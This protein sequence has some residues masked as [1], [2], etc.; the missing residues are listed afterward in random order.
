MLLASSPA[1]GQSWH[2]LYGRG[3]YG[4][5]AALLHPLVLE[6]PA[7]TGG[8]PDA[9][10]AAALARLYLDGAGVVPDHV[11][12]CSLAQLASLAAHSRYDHPD[13]PNVRRT[14]ELESAACR[15]LPDHDRDAAGQMIGC[16]VYGQDRHVFPLDAG[17]S[18]AVSR[19]GIDVEHDGV[20]R[21]EPLPT[22]CFERFVSA[23]HAVVDPAPGAREPASTRHLIEVFSW[24]PAAAAQAGSRTLQ[25][26]L[27]E[28]TGGTSRLRVMEPVARASGPTWMPAALPP[29]LL[30]ARFEMSADGEITWRFD[31]ARLAGIVE[32]L[33]V[34]VPADDG[35]VLPA[36]GRASIE[37]TVVDRAGSP[38]EGVTVTLTGVV[39]REVATDRAGWARF[40]HLPEGRYDVQASAKGL[41]AGGPRVLDLA[42]AATGAV[43]FTLK[44]Y[45]PA[46][47]VSLA[48][49]GF[50][51]RSLGALAQPAAAVL[52]V[53]IAGQSTLEDPSVLDGAVSLRTVST[54]DVLQSFKPAALAPGPGAR[55]L[56]HQTGGQI[57]RGDYIDVQTFNRLAPL[58]VGD[59]YVLLLYLDAAGAFRIHG[60][61]EGAFRVRNG[62]VEPLGSGGV[63]DGWKGRAVRRFF[64][65]LR[66]QTA[67]R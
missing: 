37:A 32:A 23:R 36:T 38:L 51:A 5:A 34:E 57:D 58:T 60:A 10:A 24:V 66:A 27:V 64:E 28:I 18:V 44:P 61:E 11:I 30:P 9:G 56:V 46:L 67:S 52:H 47:T 16:P 17:A 49:G 20:Q 21:H 6:R 40:D 25:W 53:K 13:D 55:I 59:E 22:V 62:L 45:G 41:V 35:A 42:D 1:A 14:R 33:P 2:E 54:A 3:E 29:D 63:A 43:E 31:A 65:A 8:L 19:R 15:A 39:R 26:K 4:E 7:H 50:D 12:A 48:C